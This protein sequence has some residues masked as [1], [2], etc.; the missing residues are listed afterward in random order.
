MKRSAQRAAASRDSP[1]SGGDLKLTGEVLGLSVAERPVLGSILGVPN[2]DVFG[3][4]ACG[5]KVVVDCLVEGLLVVVGASALGEDVD[6][7]DAGGAFEAE[8]GVLGDDVLGGVFGDDLEA[9]AFWDPVGVDDRLMDCVGERVW[10]VVR[11]STR[12]M[13]T[14]GMAVVLRW[15]EV[16]E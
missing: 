16:R 8:A 6:D 5:Q 4:E 12:S 10:S 3:G 11:P 15:W 13:R 9:V 7:D 14:S 1:G 2:E